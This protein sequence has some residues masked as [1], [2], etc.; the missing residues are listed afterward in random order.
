MKKLSGF[1]GANGS[2]CATEVDAIAS[3]LGAAGASMVIRA[4]GTNCDIDQSYVRVREAE[5]GKRK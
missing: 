1:E 2:F 3:V 5:K 4:I